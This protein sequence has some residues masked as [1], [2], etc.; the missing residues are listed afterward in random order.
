MPS[1]RE[2]R[3]PHKSPSTGMLD[4]PTKTYESKL[5]EP[6][7]KLQMY[8]ADPPRTMTYDPITSPSPQLPPKHSESTKKISELPETPSRLQMY[9]PR[10]ARQ[11]YSS[12]AN[13]SKKSVNIT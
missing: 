6:P 9:Y 7:S 2:L 11:M 8:S 5:H 10:S 1:A 4:Q 12:S 3:S 13:A